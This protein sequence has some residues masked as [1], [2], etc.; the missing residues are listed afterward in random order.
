MGNIVWWL[1]KVKGR[2]LTAE[3]VKPFLEA[4]EASGYLKPALAKFTYQSL[5][6]LDD[7]DEATP[8]R[9]FTEEQYADCLRE[10]HDIICTPGYTPSR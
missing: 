9:T 10:L 2:G 1:G 8:E 6:H 7:V 5:V 3:Q 4:H